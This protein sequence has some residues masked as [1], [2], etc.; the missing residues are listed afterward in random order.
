LS[1]PL[2]KKN[3]NKSMKINYL[4]MTVNVLPIERICTRTPNMQRQKAEESNII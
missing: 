3:A 1:I 4:E 2:F